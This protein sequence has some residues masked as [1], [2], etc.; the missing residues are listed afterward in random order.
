MDLFTLLI[1]L[2]SGPLSPNESFLRYLTLPQDNELAID[3][4]QTAVVIM[5]HL[6]RL[7]TPCMPPLCSSPTSHKVCAQQSSGA[8]PRWCHSE[9][10]LLCTCQAFPGAGS[11]K[12]LKVL[13]TFAVYGV[14]SV[15]TKW[16]T[17]WAHRAWGPEPRSQVP[18][19]EAP[20]RWEPILMCTIICREVPE[21]EWW[22]LNP[23]SLTV[24]CWLCG[25]CQC[26]YKL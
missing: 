8:S 7:A 6:D 3:L 25:C 1:Q 23:R 19:S 14:V 13:H 18:D 15:S 24:W 21:P 17:N 5:A 2:L 10:L 22:S 11:R 4:R 20:S 12:G 16:W 9:S 26:S